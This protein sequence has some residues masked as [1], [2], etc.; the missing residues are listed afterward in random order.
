[1]L[2]SHRNVCDVLKGFYLYYFYR[3][4]WG[5]N[6]FSLFDEKALRAHLIHI[7]LLSPSKGNTFPTSNIAGAWNA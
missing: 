6:F 5:F 1:M 3:A 2:T 4:E 7:A